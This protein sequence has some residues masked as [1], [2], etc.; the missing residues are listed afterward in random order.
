MFTRTPVW[1]RNCVVTM[2]ASIRSNHQ[3]TASGRALNAS[4]GSAVWSDTA[5][6]ALDRLAR[7]LVWKERAADD[8]PCCRSNKL[9]NDEARSIMGSNA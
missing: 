5:K 4:L 9:G 8:C 2:F 3:R 6:S 7:P 1:S